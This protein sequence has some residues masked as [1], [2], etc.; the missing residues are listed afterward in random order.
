MHSG[1]RR[2]DPGS[3]IP[4]IITSFSEQRVLSIHSSWTTVFLHT[5]QAFDF[6]VADQEKRLPSIRAIDLFYVRW[7]EFWT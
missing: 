3:E 4:Q 7:M 1:S 2:L 6:L 5:E